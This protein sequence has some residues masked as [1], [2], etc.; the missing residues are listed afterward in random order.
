MVFVRVFVMRGLRC[1][2]G[3]NAHR[4]EGVPGNMRVPARLLRQTGI[5]IRNGSRHTRA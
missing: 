3:E 2:C 5:R 1:L 4:V